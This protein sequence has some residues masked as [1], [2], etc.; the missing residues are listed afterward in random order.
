MADLDKPIAGAMTPHAAFRHQSFSSIQRTER[1]ARV[2]SI[3]PECENVPRRSEPSY[4]GYG[5]TVIHHDVSVMAEHLGCRSRDGQTIGRT[6]NSKVVSDFNSTAVSAQE[7]C[8]CYTTSVSS[9][10]IQRFCDG[11]STWASSAWVCRYSG[12]YRDQAVSQGPE[13][14]PQET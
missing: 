11:T 3:I 4:P 9:R 14:V 2:S 12:R 10:Q 13:V 5:G 8:E 6:D 1:H 7:I